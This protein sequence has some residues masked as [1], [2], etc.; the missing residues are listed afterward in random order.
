MDDVVGLQVVGTALG[1]I[2]ESAEGVV[3]INHRPSS[4]RLCD[5]HTLVTQT[6]TR[7]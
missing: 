5:V 7:L 2:T 1:Q 4:L 3:D 6:T